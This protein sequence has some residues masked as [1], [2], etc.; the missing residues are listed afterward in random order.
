MAALAHE[1]GL[2]RDIR[3]VKFVVRLLA[4]MGSSVDIFLE[5]VAKGKDLAAHTV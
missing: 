5:I 1:E 4:Q 2:P 3:R